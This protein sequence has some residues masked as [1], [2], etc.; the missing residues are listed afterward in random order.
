MPKDEKD[1]NGLDTSPE[2]VPPGEEEEKKLTDEQIEQMEKENEEQKAEIEKTK[3]EIKM[4][5]M[6]LEKIKKTPSPPK[7]DL[8]EKPLMSD[9]E[10]EK[11]MYDEPSRYTQ[12]VTRRAEERAR[13]KILDDPRI[14]GLITQN[15]RYTTI[16]KQQIDAEQ[17]LT[18]MGKDAKVELEKHRDDIVKIWQTEPDVT[19]TEAVIRVMAEKGELKPGYEPP[20]NGVDG[21]GGGSPSH[22]GD[23]NPIAQESYNEG[24]VKERLGLSLQQWNE[25][26]KRGQKNRK[27]RG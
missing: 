15:E 21:V 2:G 9:E 11:I 5:E 24:N 12:E 10:L 8:E 14:K 7:V 19:V 26:I 18:K 6:E 13:K 20:A 22:S 23:I 4:M 3:M 25:R 1:L 17:V 16:Q 27:G